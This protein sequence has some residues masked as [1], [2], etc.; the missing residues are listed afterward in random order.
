MLNEEDIPHIN[1]KML[2]IHLNTFY[3]YEKILLRVQLINNDN[4]V[5]KSSKDA[6]DCIYPDEYE[7][8]QS[9]YKYYSYSVCMTDCLKRLQIMNCNCSHFILHRGIRSFKC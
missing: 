5:R 7:Q 2:Q 8:F 3:T 6:R 9:D 1:L 4:N